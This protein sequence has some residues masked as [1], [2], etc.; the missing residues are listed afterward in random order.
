MAKTT[1]KLPVIERPTPELV[2]KTLSEM[3]EDWGFKATEKALSILFRAYPKN[4]TIEEVLLKVVTLNGLYNT[5]ILARHLVSKHICELG[6]DRTLASGDMNLIPLIAQVTIQ[7]KKG[8]KARNNY[9]FATKYCSFHFPLHYP[10][11]DKYVNALLW[12]YVALDGFT[13]LGDGELRKYPILCR[14]IAEFQQFYKLEQFT[15]KQIDKFLWKY[16]QKVHPEL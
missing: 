7:T 9:S 2:Q 5:N 15:I 4:D 8:N 13:E 1:T 3:D 12:D 11:W 14:V 16:G 6:I 10:I